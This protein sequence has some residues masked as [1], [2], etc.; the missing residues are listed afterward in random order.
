[1]KIIDFNL[2]REKENCK[3]IIGENIF[4]KDKLPISFEN[5]SGCFIVVDD[6][7]KNSIE[8]ELLKTIKRHLPKTLILYIKAGETAK[9]LKQ[10]EIIWKKLHKESFDRKSL[11]V[12]VG[13]GTVG[14][15]VGFVAATYM[16]GIDYISIPTTLLSQVDAGIGG[17][18]GVNF[19]GYKNI[20]GSFHQPKAIIIDTEILNSLPVNQ[21]NSG[22]AEVIKYAI[23]LDPILWNKLKK[24]ELEKIKKE[25]SEIIKTC[26]LLKVKI[27]Q[28]DEKEK[29]IR[30]VLNFGH[31]IGH[32]IE[33]LTKKYTHGEAISIGMVKA[34]EIGT[35]LKL[36]S[37]KLTE[38]LI[39][40][41][42]KFNLPTKLVGLNPEEIWQACQKDKK[43]TFG[44]TRWILLKDVG[45]YLLN[46]RMQKDVVLKSLR[47]N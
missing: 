29:G 18:T 27:V 42:S 39:E 23:T 40:I 8:L 22:M 11:I 30:A 24:Y 36:S 12:T 25:L 14:D 9:S 6:N 41:L 45:M 44:Q 38:E 10:A 47:D 35:N 3:I 20:I 1:M 4:K 13:G 2:K 15:L 21:F 31:T 28:E 26:I 17:K 43:N 34:L 33:S 37:P 16:R 7:L 32:A 46:Q 5:Y 19:N